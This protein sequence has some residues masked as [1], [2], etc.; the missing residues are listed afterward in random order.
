M[1][2]YPQ[3]LGW[4]SVGLVKLVVGGLGGRVGVWQLGGLCRF[5]DGGSRVGTGSFLCQQRNVLVA[6]LGREERVNVKRM[7]S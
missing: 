7:A 2:S 6:L 5:S 4:S 3:T 1:R